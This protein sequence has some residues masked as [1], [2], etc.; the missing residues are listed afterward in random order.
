MGYTT[1]F[2]GE[3]RITPTLKPEHKAYINK[4]SETRRYKREANVAATW[5]DPIREA[6]GLPIGVDAGFYVGAERCESLSMRDPKSGIVNYN[7]S[8]EGQP[9]LWCQWIANDE[10]T[11]LVWDE[12]E[13]FYN[14]VE[15]LDYLIETF[16]KLWGYTLNGEVQWY[17]QDREDIGKIEVTDNA[18][19]TKAGI[20]TYED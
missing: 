13:K 4:F 8:P 16:L 14:Y 3:F 1:E 18:V 17:G 6:A 7:E 9:G 11:E 10:G 20:I 2:S 19:K 5:P 12:G 15:W